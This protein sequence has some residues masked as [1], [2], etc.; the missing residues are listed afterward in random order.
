MTKKVSITRKVTSHCKDCF[1]AIPKMDNLSVATG[2]PILA[3]CRYQPYL[4]LLNQP[5]C[6]EFKQK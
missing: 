4:I 1:Y 5:S 2:E 6:N 3:S